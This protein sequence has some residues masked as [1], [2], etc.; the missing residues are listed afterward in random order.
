MNFWYNS[1]SNSGNIYGGSTLGKGI[2]NFIRIDELFGSGIFLTGKYF[3][4]LLLSE[5]I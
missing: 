3:D 5:N 4:N 1:S 2:H